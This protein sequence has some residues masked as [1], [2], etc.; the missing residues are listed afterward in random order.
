MNL[1]NHRGFTAA[2]EFDAED[3]ILVGRIAGINDVIGF[4]GRDAE[5]IEAAFIEAVED[6]LETCDRVGKNP[7][8]PYSGK[9]ML[10]VQ[11]S[12]H[13]Q[14]ALAAQLKG[15]SLNQFGE[16]ALRAAVEQVVSGAVAADKTSVGG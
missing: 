6:Y 3:R 10:R 2:V 12:I 15:V 9:V 7:E 14:A 1:L 5:E 13:A 8:K 4:H 11:P 16:A